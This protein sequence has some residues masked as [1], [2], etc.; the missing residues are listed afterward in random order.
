[1]YVYGTCLFMSVVVIVWRS[2]GIYHMEEAYSRA[3]LMTTL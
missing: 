2:V 1:M 3:G